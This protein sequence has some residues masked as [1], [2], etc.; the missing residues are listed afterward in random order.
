MPRPSLQ[1]LHAQRFAAAVATI[2]SK[3]WA[4]KL[5]VVEHADGRRSYPDVVEYQVKR[6]AAAAGRYEPAEVVQLPPTPESHPDE[7]AAAAAKARNKPY[8]PTTLPY[9]IHVK[10]QPAYEWLNGRGFLGDGHM[11]PLGVTSDAFDNRQDPGA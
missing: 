8:Q 11:R 3:P 5:K 2:Q 1:E 10:D 7:N 4:G 9:L 6:W